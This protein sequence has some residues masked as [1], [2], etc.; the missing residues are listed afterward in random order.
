M[1][2][3]FSTLAKQ[4]LLEQITGVSSSHASVM[5][6][7]AEEQKSAAAKKSSVAVRIDSS[8]HNEEIDEEI[9]FITESDYTYKEY[10]LLLSATF[11]MYA[12]GDGAWQVADDMLGNDDFNNRFSASFLL[13]Y[14]ID[15]SAQSL[16]S[17]IG[18]RISSHFGMVQRWN[19][20]DVANSFV[21]GTLWL[22]FVNLGTYFCRLAGEEDPNSNSAVALTANTLLLCNY[23]T[24]YMSL[25]ARR[26]L[27]NSDEKTLGVPSTRRNHQ[28][29]SNFSDSVSAMGFYLQGPLPEPGSA[30]G[31]R[32]AGW[33]SFFSASSAVVGQVIG[34]VGDILWSG[35]TSCCRSRRRK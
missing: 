9:A 7:L 27:S 12:L 2:L 23:L 31:G 30:S 29:P 8:D 21:T 15:G 3:S 18:N 20:W 10:L 13:R 6:H 32:S 19:T 28:N 14:F 1:S 11:L 16:G 5:S 34:D 33:A 35:F 26:Y 4:Q 24:L 17:T 25:T 22:P